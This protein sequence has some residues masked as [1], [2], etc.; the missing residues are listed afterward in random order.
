VKGGATIT[1]QWPAC[2]ASGLI[3]SM[4]S[5]AYAMVLY[6]FQ[7]PAITGLRMFSVLC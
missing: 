5:T 6:I 7:L 4:K 2:A 3:F 1:S